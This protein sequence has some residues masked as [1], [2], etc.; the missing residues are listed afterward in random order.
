MEWVNTVTGKAKPEELGM[1]L[2]HEHLLIGYPGW[3]MDALAPRFVRADALAKA[4]D[5]MGELRGLGVSTFLDPCPMDLGRDVEFMADV[6][7]RSGMKIVCATGAYKQNEGLTYTFGALP[8][9]EIAAIYMKELTEGI[10][11]SGIRAGIVKVASGAEEITDYER[12][13][14]TA[15][16]RA[17]AQVGC[18]V[19]T[20]TDHAS[21][22]IEQIALLVAE[23]VPAHRILVG[24]SDGRDDHVYHRSLADRGAYVGFDRFGLESLIPDERRIESVVRMVEAGYTRSVCLSHDSV[25]TWLG[26]PIFGGHAVVPAQMLEMGLPNWEPT[27][28]FKRVV[29]QLKARGVTEEQLRTIFVDNPR[30]YFQG[31]ESPR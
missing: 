7:E 24:H 17:A 3:F 2:V 31:T 15:G 10:G 12:K 16:G 6:A 21:C 18:P 25:C 14:I 28:L 30:R 27:H 19:L 4:V 8:V 5:R 29:P 20:H 9:E 13:L 26:R 22:G 23:G 11:T 1:T